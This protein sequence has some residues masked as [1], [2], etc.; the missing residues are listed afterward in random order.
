MKTLWIIVA[1]LLILSG[2]IITAG[3]LY[4]SCNKPPVH[5]VA[6]SIEAVYAQ[7]YELLKAE[8]LAKDSV[9]RAQDSTFTE[10]KKRTRS[11]T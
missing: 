4:F 11:I 1:A 10:S 7:R 3:Y 6:D 8:L 2:P 9:V 5:P